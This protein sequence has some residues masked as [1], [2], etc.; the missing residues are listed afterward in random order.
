MWNMF[1][2]NDKDAISDSVFIVSFKHALHFFSVS[3]VDFEEVF[4]CWGCTPLGIWFFK[5]SNI[6]TRV[7]SLNVVVFFVDFEQVYGS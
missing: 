7:T 5:T 2:V 3:I 1:K 6:D 4:V